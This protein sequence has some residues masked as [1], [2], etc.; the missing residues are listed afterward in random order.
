MSSYGLIY[1]CN[2]KTLKLL[3]KPEAEPISLDDIMDIGQL[4][5]LLRSVQLGYKEWCARISAYSLSK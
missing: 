4:L 3:G 5:G 1:R 2:N